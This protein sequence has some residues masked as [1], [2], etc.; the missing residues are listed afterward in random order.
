MKKKTKYKP[1]NNRLI[2]GRYISFIEMPHCKS[3]FVYCYTSW[4]CNPHQTVVEDN[5]T[6]CIESLNPLIHSP[7]SNT[8]K[9]IK[10]FIILNTLIY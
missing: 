1:I 6:T 10:F 2:L 5:S 9:H 4:Y 8:V 7:K 3:Y